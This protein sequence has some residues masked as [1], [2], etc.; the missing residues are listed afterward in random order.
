MNT[1]LVIGG[2]RG[3]GKAVCEAALARHYNIGAAARVTPVSTG[4]D[5]SYAAHRGDASGRAWPGITRHPA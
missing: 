3:I 4:E 5:E 1:V 2:S